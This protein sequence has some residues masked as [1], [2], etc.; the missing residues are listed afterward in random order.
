[1]V[2]RDLHKLHLSMWLKKNWQV[3]ESSGGC[4]LSNVYNLR[5]KMLDDSK[6]TSH[7]T[8]KPVFSEFL[9][10]KFKNEFYGIWKARVCL[11]KEFKPQLDEPP[12]WHNRMQRTGVRDA[13]DQLLFK[14]TQWGDTCG[15]SFWVHLGQF[16]KHSR[17]V[18]WQGKG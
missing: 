13:I 2:V 5:N 1:M 15:A 17:I 14:G 18:S 16:K 10:H 4:P 7:W 3:L 11:G 8:T 9:Y 6:P 12:V